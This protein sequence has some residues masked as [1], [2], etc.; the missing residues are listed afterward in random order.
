MLNEMQ[1]IKNYFHVRCTVKNNCSAFKHNNGVRF[2]KVLK[3]GLFDL[4]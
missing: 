3:Y 4:S 2:T 1:I